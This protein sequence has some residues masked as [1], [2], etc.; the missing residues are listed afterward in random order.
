MRRGVLWQIFVLLSYNNKRN[1]RTWEELSVIEAWL[2]R[3]K[4]FDNQ[5]SSCVN[6]SLQKNKQARRINHHQAVLEKARYR[7]SV[8]ERDVANY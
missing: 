7:L 2:G 8:C 1:H 4:R 6:F 3:I 5:S